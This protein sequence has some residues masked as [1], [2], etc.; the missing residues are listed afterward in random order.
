MLLDKYRTTANHGPYPPYHT[1]PYLEDYFH[2]YYHSLKS[3]PDREYIDVT[4]TACYNNG[5]T[6]GLQEE[7]D[8]LD[9]EKKYFTVS[10]HDDA[11]KENLPPDT[12][13]FNAGGNAGGIPI[14]LVCSKIPAQDIK[15]FK[16]EKTKLCSFAGSVTHPI[17]N[18]MYNEFI[19][20]A[21]CEIFVKKWEASV[22]E[23][24]YDAYLSSA[25]RS[26]FLL[27]PRGYGLNSFRLYEAFQLGCVPVVI[28]N[29]LFLPWQDTLDWSEFSV[30]VNNC[31]NLYFNLE[32]IS[33]SS[34]HTMLEV[35]Q[36]LFEKYFTLQGVCEQI[37]ERLK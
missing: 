4:W 1:G 18:S 35:G 7:L 5:E 29:K 3:K 30:V 36:K 27:C 12:V 37:I 16:S 9:R 17:R 23:S 33:D 2:N 24:Q 28:S 32:N 31:E 34:Y 26:K 21:N 8:K 15:K 11:V 20:K 19:D 6:A 22:K 25:I 10:Q 13:C 14:P